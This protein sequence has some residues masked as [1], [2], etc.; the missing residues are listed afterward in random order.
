MSAVRN[1]TV[2][3]VPLSEFDWSFNR[4]GPLPWNQTVWSLIAVFTAVPLWM[5]LELTVWVLYVF[6]RYSGLYFWSVLI[7]TWGVTIHAIGFVLKFCVPSCNWIASTTLCEIGWVGEVTG[8]SLVLYSRLNLLNCVMRN[9]YIL[10]FALTMIIVD[11][12]LFHIPTIVFQYGISDSKLHAQYLAYMNPMER[13]QVVAFSIQEI[14]LSAIYIYG[15]VLMLK[16]SMNPK[17]RVTITYLILIQVIVILC[18]AV[19][20]ALDYAQKFTLKAVIHSFVYA[21]KLQLE[22]VVLNEFREVTKGG[23]APRHL[24]QDLIES[25]IPSSDITLWRNDISS[26]K[27]SSRGSESKE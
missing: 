2:P 15:T 7:T 1:V 9:R 25:G 22:F 4:T 11:A 10:R 8:F 5:T 24:N 17:I 23:L 18:D 21:F 20:I 13:V 26:S 16:D 6:R 12:L 27:A 3:Y 19:V 14:V